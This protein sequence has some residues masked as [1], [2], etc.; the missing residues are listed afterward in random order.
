MLGPHSAAHHPDPAVLAD[1]R[2]LQDARHARPS[3]PDCWP[4]ASPS[5]AFSSSGRTTWAP[6]WWISWAASARCCFWPSS[7]AKSGARKKIWRYEGE[8]AP[9]KHA[10]GDQLTF[11]RILLA[12]S[13]FLLLA[14]FVV[15]WGLAPV[16]KTARR[17]LVEAAGARPAYAGGAHAARGRQAVRRAGAVRRFLALHAGH[18][19]VF[20]GADRRP[21]GRPL[22]QADAADLFPI[23]V[24]AAPQPGGH[25]GDARPG[26]HHALLRHGRH[27]GNG[28]GAHRRPPSR[29]SA[30]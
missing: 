8:A 9:L 13:P 28:D 26:L 20:R 21:A 2:T 5:A 30:P 19:H 6:R 18:R 12:W 27:H 15:L 3:G 7:S 22:V 25:H 24:A 11:G 16:S 23:D 10:P 17:G 29:S 1:P 14:G 4:A